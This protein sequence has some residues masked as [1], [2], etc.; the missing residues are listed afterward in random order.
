MASSTFSEARESA[1]DLGEVRL[2]DPHQVGKLSQGEL[3]QLALPADV[4][5]ERRVMCR[6]RHAS[7]CR[8]ERVRVTRPGA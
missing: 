8:F 4:A 3:L 7:L 2:G 5:A 1:L 6:C